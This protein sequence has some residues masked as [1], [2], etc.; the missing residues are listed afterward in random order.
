MPL[1]EGAD[2]LRHEIDGKALGAAEADDTA[3]KPAQASDLRD[4]LFFAQLHAPRM[5]GQQ[6]A[7][8]ARNHAPCP[9]LE[10]RRAELGFQF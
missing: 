6:I 1:A 5:L 8:G 4:H 2:D 10:Q 7:G 3:L 9:A